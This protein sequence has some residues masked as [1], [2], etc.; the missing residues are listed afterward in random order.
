MNILDV[1]VH[2]TCVQVVVMAYHTERLTPGRLRILPIREIRPGVAGWDRLRQHAK[3]IAKQIEEVDLREFQLDSILQKYAG[4][5][6]VEQ[7]FT[8]RLK[9]N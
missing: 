6:S 4:F 1:S 7:Q 9:E 5:A 8:W 3:Q 2:P